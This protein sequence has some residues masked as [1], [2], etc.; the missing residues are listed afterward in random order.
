MSSKH[1]VMFD[2]DGTLI[3]SYDFDTQCF[4]DAVESVLNTTVNA[5]WGK[6]TDVTDSGIL[7]AILQDAGIPPTEHQAFCD[8]IK[9]RFIGLIADYINS[10]DVE[11]IRGASQFIK[12]LTDRKDTDVVFATGGWLETAQ[13][14]LLAAGIDA[15]GI[16]IASASDYSRRTEIMSYAASMT[17][18]VHYE[19]ITYFGDGPWDCSASAHLGYSFILVGD[20]IN[21]TPRINDFTQPVDILALLQL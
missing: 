1:L 4:V 8:D 18:S 21:H 12:L 20:R 9:D 6:Y 19:A 10:H 2:I 13:L 11:E 7:N 15:T 17:N 3:Q 5:D 14:K 16:P